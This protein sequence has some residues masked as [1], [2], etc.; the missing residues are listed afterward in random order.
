MSKATPLDQL[1]AGSKDR[2]IVQDVL[3]DLDDDMMDE[4]EYDEME[5]QHTDRYRQYQHDPSQITQF[6]Q[7]RRLSDMPR[8]TNAGPV[9]HFQDMSWGEFIWEELKSPL[10]FVILFVLLSWP[11]IT[12][13]IVKYLPLSIIDNSIFSFISRSLE[14]ITASTISGSGM[15]IDSSGIISMKSLS[16]LTAKEAK[17]LLGSALKFLSPVIESSCDMKK[18]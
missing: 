9:E 4:P 17:L 18:S 14:Q 3:D 6:Q 1:T 2:D 12:R 16:I 5:Q 7:E 15:N 10:L 13:L 8:P 11:T